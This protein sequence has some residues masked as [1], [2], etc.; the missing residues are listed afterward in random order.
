MAS[1]KNLRTYTKAL[2]A[3]QS[4]PL[5][6]AGDMFALLKSDSRITIEFDE[7]NVLREVPEGASSIFADSYQRVT[8]TSEAS[9]VV[10]LVLGFGQFEMSNSTQV[11]NVTA[12][13][14]VPNISEFLNASIDTQVQL[15]PVESNRQSVLISVLSTATNGVRI[16]DVT[17]ADRTVGYLLEVGQSLTLSGSSQIRI[18]S[19][20]AGTSVDI[21]YIVQ[22]VV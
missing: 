17:T 22:K 21:T 15:L 5:D 11:A 14:A 7:S 2:T 18:S 1:Q 19:A 16:T 8:L 10:T 20:V 9:Q 4:I 3:G 13:I 12:S 6:V